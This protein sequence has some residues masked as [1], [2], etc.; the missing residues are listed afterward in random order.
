MDIGIRVGDDAPATS[1]VAGSPVG[2]SGTCSDYDRPRRHF[3]DGEKESPMVAEG[4]VAGDG[5]GGG[6]KPCHPHHRARDLQPPPHQRYHQPP[7]P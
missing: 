4:D 3:A 7:P 1:A 6:G 2:F 5:C